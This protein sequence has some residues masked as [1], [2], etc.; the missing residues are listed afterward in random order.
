M[1]GWKNI[2]LIAVFLFLTLGVSIWMFSR[3]GIGE[4]R[5]FIPNKGKISPGDPVAIYFSGPFEAKNY[6][7][8]ITLNPRVNFRLE[9]KEGK[10]L[11][12]PE[13]FWPLGEKIQI[14]LP[15]GR[16]FLIFPIRKQSLSFETVDYPGL[17]S[18]FPL[19]GS[20]DV[21]IGIEDP[22][23]INF[24]SSTLGFSVV[25][26]T[27]PERELVVESDV[28]KKKFQIL[29]KQA[30]QDG[31]TVNLDIWVKY[32]KESDSGYKKIY[33]G[34]FTT[35]PPV[36]LEWDKDLTLRLAQAKRLTRP[37]I[38]EGKYIDVNLGSQVMSIFEN[39]KIL[40]SFLISSG[41]RG[42]ET[43]KGEHQIYNK[44]PRTWSKQYGLYMPFWMAITPGGKY[45]I[46]ELPEWPGGYKEGANHLG[47]PVS[48]GCM[49]LG[50]GAA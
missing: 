34:K 4:V 35:L 18:V 1:K 5:F 37:K 22:I 44:S 49:R 42:M 41:K 39:G 47:I 14:N 3:A 7:E 9:E 27:N 45:G 50:V 2:L 33:S 36:P 12:Y 10:V 38:V 16:N 29:P 19:P 21:S 8:G 25:F 11:I 30:F 48:H 32:F 20:E 46:H 40:D 43:P 13:T 26:K 17:G 31:E 15:E 23:E 24:S 6:W 28:S